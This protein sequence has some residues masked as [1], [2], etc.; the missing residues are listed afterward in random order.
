ME[1]ACK[2][3]FNLDHIDEAWS[4]PGK[5]DEQVELAIS[6]RQDSAYACTSHPFIRVEAIC[7][8]ADLE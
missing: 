8:H 6:D 5:A 2:A 3:N 1:T 7:V 4:L